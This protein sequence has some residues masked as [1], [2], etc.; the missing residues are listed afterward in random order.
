[1]GEAKR[2]EP[3]QS[4]RTVRHTEEVAPHTE[5]DREG[6]NAHFLAK[7]PKSKNVVFCFV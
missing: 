2:R 1:M 6:D 4:Q 5:E 7:L 3:G